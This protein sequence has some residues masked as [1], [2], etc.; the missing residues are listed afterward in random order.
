[1]T[2]NI[3]IEVLSNSAVMVATQLKEVSSHD[4]QLIIMFLAQSLGLTESELLLTPTLYHRF[5]ARAKIAKMD[6]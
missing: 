5:L 3:Q 2:G 6:L 4:K 1:M